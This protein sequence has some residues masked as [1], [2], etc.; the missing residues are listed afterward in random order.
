[1]TLAHFF[2]LANDIRVFELLQK[3]HV[4]LGNLQ[5][6]PNK[7][8]GMREELKNIKEI[9]AESLP[10]I[11]RS[12]TLCT[13]DTVYQ[14]MPLKPGVFYGRDE[15]IE[16]ITHLLMKEE[17]SRICILGPGGMGKT[18][19]SLG[20]VEQLFIK[21]RFL[22][23]NLVWVPCI[24]ATS[25][26][27]LLEVLYTQ[28]QL[29]GS[30]QVTIETIIS[31]LN[32]STHP[33]LILLDNFETPCNAIDGSQ[34]KVEDIL[35]RIAM[36]SHVAILVTMRGRYPPC[37]EAIQWQSKDIR[38]TD[39]AAC[40]RIYHSIYPDSENDRDVGTLLRLLG[41]M[42]FAVTLMARLAK[43]GRTTAK[44]SLSEWSEY[45]PDI[46]PDHHE[47]SMNR[48]ISLSVDSYLMKQN[49]Q[50]LLL[51]K[52][53]SCLPAGTPKANL[54]WW[55]P[56]LRLVA[57]AV[58]TLPKAGLLVESERHDS[59]SPNLFVLPVVQSFMQ[60]QGRIEEEIR[61]N[62][63]SSC[64]QYV[65]DHAC[66]EDEPAFP[67]KSK[68]LAAEDINIQ[69]ILYGTMQQHD[70]TLSDKAIAALVA[71]GWYR[72]DTKP[73][74]EIAKHNVTMAKA[75]GA[76]RY[77]AST[78]WCLGMTHGILDEPYDAYGHLHEAYQLFNALPSDGDRELQL[79]CCRFGIDM[80]TMTHMFSDPSEA[81]SKG[82]DVGKQCATISD[83]LLHGR[84]L[85]VLGLALTKSDQHQ[86]ALH[87]LGLAK[88]KVT[89]SSFL[90]SGAFRT[91]AF[92][93]YNEN[94]LLDA[95]DA[96]KEAWELA[97]SSN[98]LVY[99]AQSSFY[100]G[101]ILFSA[102]RDAEAW[103]YIEIFLRKSSI[104]GIQYDKATALEYMGYGYLR[105]GDYLNAYGA[106]EAAAENYRGTDD[107]ESDVTTRCKD[108]MAKIKVKQKNPDLNVGF[109]KPRFDRDCSSLFYP[110][111][112]DIS[113]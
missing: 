75:F 110:T 46:L 58:A 101:G 47:Q 90:L 6:L 30:K 5:Q 59:A 53:L 65:L 67:I 93:H 13:S 98:S 76:K 88:L 102:D 12:A 103:K 54:R 80:V 4:R 19:V 43:E 20:V 87:H 78:L 41:H 15:I 60:Q 95:L 52:I 113:R 3:L 37:D 62:I 106:Y 10:E 26:T 84:S 34:K 64:Y 1:M 82:R 79:L 38:P 21:T 9:L 72:C 23:E 104:L 57:S 81:I 91:I 33:R 94:R 97:E 31:L 36:L 66:R 96:M 89:G 40:L 16:E 83:D 112:Q 74:I 7:V 44:E 11:R 109:V 48:S 56:A 29:P 28:L 51:L 85:I 69:A 77:I 17:T 25:A 45:G 14:Q 71:F 18:S 39:E 111:V 105:R 61:H 35:R 70:N 73:N 32:T 100:L 8:D 27:L 107:E 42:P 22:P 49:P 50:A 92:V 68:A 99:Q 63:Q 86:E 2:K 24:E 108:N 55:A